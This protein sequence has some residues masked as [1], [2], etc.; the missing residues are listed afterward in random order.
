M[1]KLFAF[2]LFALALLSACTTPRVAIDQTAELA[3]YQQRV[4]LL[5]P[6][7]E[8][9][10]L[11]LYPRVFRGLQE[12]GFNVT[13]VPPDQAVLGNQGTAF[14][15]DYQG[16][17]LTSAHIFGAST[18]ATLWLNGQRAEAS[19]IKVDEDADLALLKANPGAIPPQPLQFASQTNYRLGAE[20]YSI[21]FPLS[22][23]LGRE[24]RLNQGLISATVG[25]QDNPDFI[26]VSVETQP[27]NSGSPLFNEQR[28]VIGVMQATINAAEMMEATGGAAP[29][30][31]N[32]A[33][34]LDQVRAFLQGTGASPVY[35]PA[36]VG[37]DF[38]SLSQSV[39]QVRSGR[40]TDAELASDQLV[41]T[42]LY[43]QNSAAPAKLNFFQLVFIDHKSGEIVLSAGQ[44][45][46]NVL[47]SN[48]AVI[49]QTL[50]EVKA[51]LLAGS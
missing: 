19:V 39:A 3:D 50:Q 17:F 28:Q 13:S 12:I 11:E 24:P 5:E 4:F 43:T 35:S 23:F 20:V 8:G 42:V 51:K 48:E 16:H 6:N 9:D 40:I 7:E 1:R 29:Q 45:R 37:R 2:S 26:Q 33:L 15:L 47:A 44:T 38:E 46:G 21:G 36:P 10:P 41:C 34:K 14:P 32:F 22:D 31:L 49:E 27:G 18:N 25:I 30:N